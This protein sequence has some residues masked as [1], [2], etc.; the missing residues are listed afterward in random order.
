MNNSENDVFPSVINFSSNNSGVPENLSGTSVEQC[1]LRE[2]ERL[3]KE[4]QMLYE[5]TKKVYREQVLACPLE[6][7]SEFMDMACSIELLTKMLEAVANAGNL[8]AHAQLGLLHVSERNPNRDTQKGWEY[9]VNAG[10]KGNDYALC[11]GSRMLICSN[12]YDDALEWLERAAI[13][14]GSY[15][16]SEMCGIF[17]YFGIGTKPNR[18]RAIRYFSQAD[19]IINFGVDN[20]IDF[21]ESYKDDI[22][23][24]LMRDVT[25]SHEIAKCWEVRGMFDLALYW[26]L[27]GAMRYHRPSLTCASYYISTETGGADH[28]F[29]M[30]LFYDQLVESEPAGRSFAEMNPIKSAMFNAVG[31]LYEKVADVLPIPKREELEEKVLEEARKKQVRNFLDAQGRDKEA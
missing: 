14:R 13:M 5:K 7:L 17:Y 16:G 4:L 9:I 15:I 21:C 22:I 2:Q 20:R 6:K 26:F 23:L 25:K 24:G 1:L 10:A 19:K 18:D 8:T 11:L 12:Q 28:E 3:D 27:L 29:E 31:K 30:E